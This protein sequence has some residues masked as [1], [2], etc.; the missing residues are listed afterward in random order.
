[1]VARFARGEKEVTSVV[2]FHVVLILVGLAVLTGVVPTGRVGS[3]LSYLHK[4]IGITTPST[5]QVR[6]VAFIWIGSAI[7]MVDGSLLLLLLI[8]SLSKPR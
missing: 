8:T 5:K 4:S 3:A 6:M 7:V 2:L 1:V